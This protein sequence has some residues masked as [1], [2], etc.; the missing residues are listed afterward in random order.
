MGERCVQREACAETTAS[1]LTMRVPHL[2]LPSSI[3]LA[4]LGLSAACMAPRSEA[5]DEPRDVIDRANWS[6]SV[7]YT[8]VSGVR[9]LSDGGFLVSDPR[10]ARL[11][12]RRADTLTRRA[13][14]RQGYGPGEWP[15][16]LAPIAMGWDSSLL[17]DP[18]SRRVLLI[19]SASPVAT[20][21]LP[22]AASLLQ[23]VTVVGALD[24]RRLVT[25]RVP[26]HVA[27]DPLADSSD[28]FV[29]DM[30]TDQA[31]RIA[32]LRR[33][34]GDLVQVGNV[35]ALSRPAFSVAEQAAV[36]PDRWIAVARRSP[37]RIDW[38]KPDG[39][40]QLGLAI[41]RRELPMNAREAT[42]YASRMAWLADAL[43][44]MPPEQRTVRE[45]LLND[46]PASIPP[47]EGAAIHCLSSGEVAVTRTPSSSLPHLSVDI[48][49][50]SGK[51]IAAIALPS[52][53][54][55]V[56][57]GHRRLYVVSKDTLSLERISRF[58]L[59]QPEK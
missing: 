53:S 27:P 39:A 19:S 57:V 9:E 10:E 49:D 43:V 58:D 21:A 12:L 51:R 4:C 37:Y 52:M 42:Y 1:R 30:D 47:F 54:R 44:N 7:G 55:V 38:R 22:E 16:A 31:V 26:L 5:V 23:G 36:C 32:Q 20:R 28:L 25:V 2:T 8:Y 41:E 17:V 33:A 34:E 59:P 15:R 14:G 3:A 35:Q 46:L 50:R 40:W 24:S 6:D 29:L 56:G 18:L 13:V 48:V 45:R 11:E